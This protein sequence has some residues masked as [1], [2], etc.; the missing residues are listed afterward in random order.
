MKK[1]EKILAA[2]VLA[3]AALGAVWYLGVLKGDGDISFAFEEVLGQTR[4]KSQMSAW[5]SVFEL[6]SLDNLV[7][8]PFEDL[9]SR[10]SGSGRPATDTGG[11]R[12]SS[13]LE[14]TGIFEGS[15][16]ASAVVGGKRVCVGDSVRGMK[17]LAIL[18][19]GIRLTDGKKE[20]VIKLNSSASSAR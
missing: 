9:F 10:K 11:Q 8:D 20:F 5:H 7:S 16:G 14:V 4:G 6:K 13:S 17:V 18:E 2:T 19:D 15:E 1:S 12:I 3:A